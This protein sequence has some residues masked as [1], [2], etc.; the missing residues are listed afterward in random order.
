MNLKQITRQ[1]TVGG[2]TWFMIPFETLRDK[3]V[4]SLLSSVIAFPDWDRTAMAFFVAE[5]SAID[6]V[7]APTAT[8]EQARFKEYWQSRP[9]SMADRWMAFT[10]F[11]TETIVDGIHEAYNATRDIQVEAVHD[12]EPKAD[13]ETTSS[14]GG[15]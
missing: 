15:G 8:P 7:F 3:H 10:L 1:H 4:F 9:A 12:P 2:I 6:A 5:A 14:N 13:A 11:A